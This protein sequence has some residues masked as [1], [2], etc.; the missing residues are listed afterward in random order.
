MPRIITR[1]VKNS[2][3]KAT[4][5]PKYRHETI[6]EF[7]PFSE[8]ESLGTGPYSGTDVEEDRVGVAPKSW[9]RVKNRVMFRSSSPILL[10]ELETYPD[11]MFHYEILLRPMCRLPLPIPIANII[12]TFGTAWIWTV[13]DMFRALHKW[14]N[15]QLSAKDKAIIY[16]HD[17]T[18]DDWVPCRIGDLTRDCC[19]YCTEVGGKWNNRF[20]ICTQD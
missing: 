11:N 15:T 19:F 9:C 5:T 4:G 13:G 6:L 8:C 17:D 1:R 14:Y 20:D 2:K 3:R 12:T 16:Q 10:H 7:Y 18:Y